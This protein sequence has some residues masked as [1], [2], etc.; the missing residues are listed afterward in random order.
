MVTLATIR[1]SS[2]QAIYNLLQT[3]DYA[4]STDQIY[5]AMNDGLVSSKTLPII[6]IGKPLVR[7]TKK[8][9]N[10]DGI[11]EA[12]VNFTIRIFHNTAKQAEV[13]ADEVSNSFLTGWRT[14]SGNGLKNMDFQ[15]SDTDSYH[16]KSK[17]IHVQILNLE[18]TYGGVN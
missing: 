15:D 18:F 17:K 5:S 13:L 16:E 14:L 7:I 4:I 2:W 1:N 8:T 6:V 11:K 12:S 10:L 9:L 3:G